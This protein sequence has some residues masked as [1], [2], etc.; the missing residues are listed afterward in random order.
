M[1]AWGG[2]TGHAGRADAPQARLTWSLKPYYT[3][4]SQILG[5]GGPQGVLGRVPWGRTKATEADPPSQHPSIAPLW[6]RS[7]LA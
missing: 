5:S 4:H 1:G 2:L 3:L 7:C 6:G